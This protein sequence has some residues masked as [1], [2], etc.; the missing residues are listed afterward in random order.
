MEECSLEESVNP[1]FKL[2]DLANTY[3]AR[4]EQ[5]GAAVEGRIHSTRLKTRLLSVFP[6]LRECKEGCNVLLTF[7]KHIGDAI[8]KA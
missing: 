1:V 3:K 5:L 2:A 4:L 7:D 8:R 6:D